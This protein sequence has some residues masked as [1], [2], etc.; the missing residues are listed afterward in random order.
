MATPGSGDVGNG[1]PNGAGDKFTPAQKKKLKQKQRKEAR[2]AERDAIEQARR[3]PSSL[4][5]PSPA[6]IEGV[7]I[8]YVSAP[9]DFELPGAAPGIKAEAGSEDMPVDEPA[10]A[11]LGSSSLKQEE[12]DAGTAPSTAAEEDPAAELARIMQRFGRVEDMLGTSGA[13]ADEAEERNG[14]AADGRGDGEAQEQDPGSS[15]EE[16]GEAQLSKKKLRAA[17]RLKVA[18]LKQ[19]CARPDVVEIW[20]VTAADPKLLVHLKGYR[21]TVP[22]PRHWS[23]KRAYL[24]GKRGI[25]KAPFQ[26]PDFIEATGIGEMRQAYLEKAETQKLK[27][28]A[29]ERMQPKMGKLDID[30]QVLH[31]AFFK[32]QNKPRLS[33]LGEL[34]Y[35]GKEFEADIKHATPGVLSEDLQKALGI[36]PGMPPPWLIHMQ[37]YGPPPSYPSLRIP[38]L[39]SPI[40]AGAQFGYHQ[41]GWGKPPVDEEGRPVYG[42][43]FGEQAAEEAEEEEVPSVVVHW[44]EMEEE[45]EEE[46]TSSEEE[47]EEEGGSG[48]EVDDS[49]S[50]ADGLASVASGLASTLPSGIDTPSEIDLRKGKDTGPRQLYTVLEQTA[51]T[52]GAGVI[53]GS[54]HTYVLP[55]AGEKKLSIAAQKRLEALRR[56]VPSDL[57]VAIDPAELEGL[58]DAA[59]RELYEGRVVE[60]RE[61]A[62]REDFSDMVAA[63]AAAQKRKAADKAASKDTKKFKF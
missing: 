48:G 35:E 38:G 18:E 41:G 24:Q 7:E 4:S 46:E 16:G 10:T 22:V 62:G 5:K 52:G 43:V 19:A 60:A 47:E 30:Y 2:R 33:K 26:L 21:N 37:R 42:D 44:G 32:Y 17:S 15:D 55:G 12:A 1:G 49:A 54:D 57:D 59:L 27:S 50:L 53:M 40:P 31:D 36:D 34:Y 8:E 39:N 13:E 23:Q 45:E 63:K 51:A 3:G 14:G 58:S 25:E 61:A 28:K 20:D 6:E 11:G 9:L 29:R 56:E